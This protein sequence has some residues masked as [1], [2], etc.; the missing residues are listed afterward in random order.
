MMKKHMNYHRHALRC[1]G[2]SFF[3][4][5]FLCLSQLLLWV[6][7]IALLAFS[8]DRLGLFALLI[9]IPALI[10]LFACRF[11]V[12]N[13]LLRLMDPMAPALKSFGGLLL[14]AVYRLL[15]SALWLIPFL[16]VLY[17]F[18]QYIFVL[19]ATTFSNDF[20]K[21][22]AFFAADASLANQ[23]LIG[24]AAF[25]IA[26]FVTGFIFLY[27]YRKGNCFDLAQMKDLSFGESCRRARKM[28]RASR[29]RRFLNTAIHSLLLLPAVIIPCALP[30]LQMYPL[31]T[32]KVMNDIQLIYAY[33]SAG[34]VSDGTL[35]LSAVLFLILYL[36]LLPFRKLHNIAAV[37]VRHE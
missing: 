28:R 23:L 32:G 1:L 5:L 15:V 24:T 16:A 3:P 4:A 36:P 26:L 35:I 17:R 14:S 33:L 21:I 25:F 27:G 10:L 8:A 31:L 34:I 19:P 7:F 9:L 18:Y 12:T 30:M 37:V 11:I 22:G 6:G 20:T 29:K 13:K 2:R